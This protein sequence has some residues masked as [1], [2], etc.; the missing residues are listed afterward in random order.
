MILYISNNYVQFYPNN[1]TEITSTVVSLLM[2]SS[3]IIIIVIIS[4][5]TVTI[6]TNI[7]IANMIINLMTS[8]S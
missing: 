6:N 8:V 1:V 2:T 7:I 3:I 5:Q 4:T